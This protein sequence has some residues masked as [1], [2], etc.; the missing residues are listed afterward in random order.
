[1]TQKAAGCIVKAIFPD[2]LPMLDY[3]LGR[4]EGASISSLVQ[5]DDDGEY[6]ELLYHAHVVDDSFP[7]SARSNNAP[8]QQPWTQPRL[9]SRKDVQE[10]INRAIPSMLTHSKS[11]TTQNCLSFGYR[12]KSV[13]SQV[14]MRNNLNIEHYHINSLHQLLLTMAWQK[15]VSR[16]GEEE[17]RNLLTKKIFVRSKHGSYIQ[18]CGSMISNQNYS[19]HADS[20]SRVTK[21]SSTG[22]STINNTNKQPIDS[23]R[24]NYRTT[25]SVPP[26]STVSPITTNA[27]L[28]FSLTRHYM[29]YNTRPLVAVGGLPRGHP[30]YTLDSRGVVQGYVLRKYLSSAISKHGVGDVDVSTAPLA[31]GVC[32]RD[33]GMGDALPSIPQAQMLSKLLTQ[34]FDGIIQRQRMYN[35]ADAL[36]KICSASYNSSSNIGTA[37]FSARNR[38]KRGCRAGT[39]AQMKKKQREDKLASLLSVSSRNINCENNYGDSGVGEVSTLGRARVTVGDKLEAAN[40]RHLA[41]DISGGRIQAHV[42][43][44]LCSQQFKET[45]P[46]L[47]H[48]V[49]IGHASKETNTNTQE[50][51]EMSISS[52]TQSKSAR[53]RIKRK[54]HKMLHD[55]T[56][57]NTAEVLSD[58]ER[59]MSIHSNLATKGTYQHLNR[60]FLTHEKVSLDR[61]VHQNK[62]D[63]PVQIVKATGAS[64]NALAPPTLELPNPYNL[65]TKSARCHAGEVYMPAPSGKSASNA[66]CIPGS[67]PTIACRTSTLPSLPVQSTPG[68]GRGLLARSA[69]EPSRRLQN[70]GMHGIPTLQPAYNLFPPSLQPLH[71]QPAGTTSQ[72]PPPSRLFNSMLRSLPLSGIA[73]SPDIA[74]PTDSYSSSNRDLFLHYSPPGAVAIEEKTLLS[75][76]PYSGYSLGPPPFGDKFTGDSN[77][78][79][80]L[81]RKYCVDVKKLQSV[82]KFYNIPTVRF[83]PKKHTV[84]PIANLSNKPLR[85]AYTFNKLGQNGANHDIVVSNSMLY[86]S[87]FV[88]KAIY[89]IHPTLGGA[90]VFSAD[91]I[92]RQLSAYKQGIMKDGRCVS[93]LYVA[94][95]DVEKC[96][97]HIDCA[98]VFD[99]V[100]KI[101]RSYTSQESIDCPVQPVELY[102]NLRIGAQEGTPLEDS[103]E[104]IVIHKYHVSQPQYDKRTITGL[105]NKPVRYVSL[106]GSLFSFSD[107]VPVLANL[108]PKSVL[109]DHVVYGQIGGEELVDLL[110]RHLFGHI[111][112]MPAPYKPPVGKHGSITEAAGDGRLGSKG[113]C[114]EA[115]VSDSSSYYYNQVQ[116]IPQG[117]VLSALLCTFYYGYIE[118]K[119][120]GRF[121]PANNEDELTGESAKCGDRR[122]MTTGDHSEEGDPLGII[123]GKSCLLRCIDDYL[124]ISTDPS[125]VLHFLSSVF[126]TFAMDYNVHV[127]MSKV[128]ANF[129]IT[130]AS[131]PASSQVTEAY[132]SDKIPEFAISTHSITPLDVIPWCGWLLDCSDS[133]NLLQV[134]PDFARVMKQ[135]SSTSSIPNMRSLLKSTC[136]YIRAKSHMLILDGCVLNN[137]VTIYQ[138]IAAVFTVAA[139]RMSISVDKLWKISRTTGGHC[140]HLLR[141]IRRSILYGARLIQ[142]RSKNLVN[143]FSGGSKTQQLYQRIRGMDGVKT[144]KTDP[145]SSR[146][147]RAKGEN[148]VAGIPIN[149][150]IYLGWLA[151]HR[152]AT[153]CCSVSSCLRQKRLLIWV[154]KSELEAME[155]CIWTAEEL[156]AI[157]AI[158]Y[159]T[160]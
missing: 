69:S 17:F 138:N 121:L 156:A 126:T 64:N 97:D 62:V 83:V 152:T 151:F 122:S 145:S 157:Q 94:V 101:V 119:V 85:P 99:I 104:K 19:A 116:G 22:Q 93:K 27:T 35:Y 110:G 128:K 18:V 108:Y 8:T 98:T 1:M 144:E 139:F 159:L 150:V 5:E 55:R 12:Q 26:S 58:E 41:R 13:S 95:L 56:H 45:S 109:A 33:G 34:I 4:L 57:G 36:Q 117:S 129:E 136:N 102:S 21:A 51:G 53:K 44:A 3:L 48:G 6:K 141:C 78:K 100:D 68:A 52:A 63:V 40:L 14:T 77:R 92:Y 50:S 60:T 24:P 87:Y 153:T 28:C 61:S 29:L 133:H 146:Q 114:K 120:F 127:N 115:V 54:L 2:A 155:A 65:D 15:L 148:P 105:V 23:S 140:S 39:H 20:A 91:D 37:S 46:V 67:P 132:P 103:C 84:R 70:R 158:N 86:N 88:L 71:V 43:F 111:V 76:K 106:Q 123:S 75:S 42:P 74:L 90:A 10:I 112:K 135:A 59:M 49:T 82:K 25:L 107:I 47:E 38:R 80:Q 125:Y 81:T 147:K 96:F 73:S 79:I 131:H 113:D 143:R 72:A 11:V 32:K 149:K 16:I 118:H 137:L 142:A 130:L 160:I 31:D 66:T 124:M 134:R 89:D 7:L 154:V 9:Y 30:M